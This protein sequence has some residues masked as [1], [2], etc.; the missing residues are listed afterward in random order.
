MMREA[1]LQEIHVAFIEEP[2]ILSAEDFL[3]GCHSC[4]ESAIIPFEYVLDSM[5]GCDPLS[6][7]LMYRLGKCPRCFGEINE[8]TLVSVG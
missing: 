2:F 8:K 5:T 6:E 3:S 4:D 1:T 7:F